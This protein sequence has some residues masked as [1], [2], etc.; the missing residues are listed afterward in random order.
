M[1]KQ[2][3]NQLLILKK[4]YGEE[5]FNQPKRLLAFIK[6]YFPF[7]KTQHYLLAQSMA[8]DIY[9]RLSQ[10]DTKQYLL[11]RHECIRILHEE[12]MMD[13]SLAE[14]AVELWMGFIKKEKGND[15]VFSQDKLLGEKLGEA[16]SIINTHEEPHLSDSL[17]TILHKAHSYYNGEGVQRNSKE[18]IKWYEKAAAM[19]HVEA[20]LVLGNIYYMGQGILKDDETAFKWYTKAADLGSAAAMNYI[21]NMYYEGK[22]I[23]KNLEKAILFYEKAACQGHYTAMF[24]MG[25]IYYEAHMKGWD[26]PFEVYLKAALEGDIEAINHV[27]Y[28]YHTGSDIEQNYEEAFKWYQIAAAKDQPS[29]MIWLAYLYLNGQGAPKDYLKA[30]YW[31]EKAIKMYE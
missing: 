4:T 7:E 1:Q 9:K 24:N 23:E 18:A 20:M 10:C 21:G 29:A 30:S 2:I 27:A 16:A 8:F 3:I 19:G 25:Y 12:G 28:S 31:C 5:L 11:E 13:R 26:E 22:G 15:T 6:D 17:S 14:A